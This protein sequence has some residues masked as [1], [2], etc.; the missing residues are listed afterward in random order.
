M[1]IPC[2]H[3]RR[4]ID[5]VPKLVRYT[6][7]AKYL[8]AFRNLVL[9]ILEMNV[10]ENLDTFYPDLKPQLRLE[11]LKD[12]PANINDTARMAL[13]VDGALF[14]TGMF[15]EG[16]QYDV[17]QKKNI[18]TVQVKWLKQRRKEIKNNA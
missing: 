4:T 11:V 15:S 3:V 8:N 13:N 18:G 7:V 16:F 5:K 14:G 1:L 12:S 17:P 9:F 10:I 6:S 2:D